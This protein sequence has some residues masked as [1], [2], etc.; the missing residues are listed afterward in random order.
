MSCLNDQTFLLF[1]RGYQYFS[2]IVGIKKQFSDV[3]MIMYFIDFRNHYTIITTYYSVLLLYSY[4]LL[5]H[6]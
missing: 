2:S 6:I 3:Y 5:T 1:H 4:K